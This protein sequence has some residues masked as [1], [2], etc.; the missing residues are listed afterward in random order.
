M[1]KGR[2]SCL[3]WLG[4]PRTEPFRSRP[5]AVISCLVAFY[6]AGSSPQQGTCG[7]CFLHL[8]DGGM[9]RVPSVALPLGDTR[10]AASYPASTSPRSTSG[11][12]TCR[13]RTAEWRSWPPCAGSG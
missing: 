3:V 9:P 7:S 4:E 11:A 13:G 5:H 10:Q 8:C 12:W 2:G 1:E 6:K